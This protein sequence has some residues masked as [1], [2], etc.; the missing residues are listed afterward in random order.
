MRKEC[1]SF[2]AAGLKFGVTEGAIRHHVRAWKGTEAEDF[3]LDSGAENR[4]RKEDN[5]SGSTSS[6][7]SSSQSRSSSSKKVKLI[8]RKVITLEL[9]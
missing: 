4:K 6:S 7:S 5:S 2:A 1:D 3:V 8:S 9:N